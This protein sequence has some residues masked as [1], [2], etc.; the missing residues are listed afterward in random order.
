MLACAA[1]FDLLGTPLPDGRAAIL[2]ALRR[3]RL[4]APCKAGG[5]DITNLGAIL[6]AKDLGGFPRLGRKAMR[7]IRYRGAS[8]IETFRE[9]EDTKGYAV[10]F[11]GLIG[12]ID[13]WLPAN[14]VIGP[15]LRKT[16]RAF[17]VP[18]VREL[19]ANALIHQDFSVTGAGPMVE[20]FDGEQ[21]L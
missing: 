12:H 11:D 2:D 17:P 10:G 6:F 19:V 5:F 13:A 18:A 7:V 15:A 8:R 9:H 3:D 21:L 4:I 1:Y 16:V 20:I 14:E